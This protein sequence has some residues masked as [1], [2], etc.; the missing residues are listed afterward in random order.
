MKWYNNIEW[1]IYQNYDSSC[2]GSLIEKIIR[3]KRKWQTKLNQNFGHT[4]SR[5]KKFTNKEIQRTY[6]PI[7]TKPHH[8][9]FVVRGTRCY[10]NKNQSYCQWVFL[11]EV[12]S[13][14]SNK[15]ICYFRAISVGHLFFMNRRRYWNSNY[16][17]GC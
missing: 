13:R 4:C 10:D 1:S 2:L 17:L 3:T 11:H 14:K 8:S 12:G 9:K 16:P 5:Q 6:W 15:R 7:S